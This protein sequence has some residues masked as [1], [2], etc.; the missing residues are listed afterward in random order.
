MR[1]TDN[2]IT[3][4]SAITDDK[5]SYKATGFATPTNV[6]NAHAATDAAITEI[7]DTICEGTYSYKDFM[8]IM[9]AIMFGKASGGNTTNIKFR[10]VADTKDRIDET[11][12]AYGNRTSVTLDP[13]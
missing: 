13:D 5:D 4:L 6:T 9:G 3:S 1:G 2:A 12:D 10:D 11:V 8:R 7:W